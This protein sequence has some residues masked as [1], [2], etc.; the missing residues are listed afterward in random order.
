MRERWASTD[1]KNVGSSPF[2]WDCDQRVR[3]L[4][5]S[6][7]KNG[8]FRDFPGG[9]MVKNLLSK[10][11]GTSLIPGW[12]LRSHIIGNAL[13]H[14]RCISLCTSIREKPTCSNKDPMQPKITIKKQKRM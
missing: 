14:L 4:T 5:G 7:F 1:V 12:D 6:H 9:P 3:E 10:A 2:K 11:G 8:N 13:V